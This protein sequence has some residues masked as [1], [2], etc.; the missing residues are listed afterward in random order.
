M[1]LVLTGENQLMTK[2]LAPLGTPWCV[3][4]CAPVKEEAKILEGNTFN[5]VFVRAFVKHGKSLRYILR[6]GGQNTCSYPV[7]IAKMIPQGDSSHT[8][9][10]EQPVYRWLL[11]S[12]PASALWPKQNKSRK[13]S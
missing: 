11:F 1:F 12:R 7:L 4:I 8:Q 10:I 13:V 9:A 5:S 6:A 2:R 3:L